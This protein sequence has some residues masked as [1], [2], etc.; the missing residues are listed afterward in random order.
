MPST[1]TISPPRYL[2]TAGVIEQFFPGLSAQ[3][4]W[5]YVRDEGLPALRARRRLYFDPVEVDAWVR[6]RTGQSGGASAELE[7]HVRELVDQFPPL[8]AAQVDKIA[9]MLRTSP[10]R[11]A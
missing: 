11:S 9:L 8:T 5:K 6:S 1:T 7:Q 10:R 3:T 2:N 4:V